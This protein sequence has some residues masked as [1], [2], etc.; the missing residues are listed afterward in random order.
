MIEEK[1]LEILGNKGASPKLYLVKD[2]NSLFVWHQVKD[3]SPKAK[4]EDKMMWWREITASLKLPCPLPN[5]T[6][7]N[8]DEHG[9]SLIF[10]PIQ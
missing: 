10:N 5:E 1:P 4:K 9:W 8:E 3:L 2:F 7:M 6:W